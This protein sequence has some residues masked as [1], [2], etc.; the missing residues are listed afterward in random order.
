[1]EK[2]LRSRFVVMDCPLFAERGIDER[3]MP[4]AT[5]Q[6]GLEQHWL[7][8]GMEW[9]RF[10]ELEKQLEDVGELIVDG[11]YIFH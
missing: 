3:K 6:K 7:I 2:V 5:C 11:A 10:R 9:Q 4:S 1:M 8:D